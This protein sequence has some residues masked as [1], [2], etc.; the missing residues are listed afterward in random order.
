MFASL[1][2]ELLVF[3]VILIF[4][5]LFQWIRN[6][7]VL[8]CGLSGLLCELVNHWA[9]VVTFLLDTVHVSVFEADGD[10]Q[11]R[12]A[13]WAIIMQIGKMLFLPCS[14]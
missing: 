5:V 1:S 13:L 8:L 12:F 2:G 7:G 10:M 3:D 9:D 11:M 14:F 6:G 4:C